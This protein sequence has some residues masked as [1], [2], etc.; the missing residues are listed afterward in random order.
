MTVYVAVNGSAFPVSVGD[1]RN[2]IDE[3]IKHT[4]PNKA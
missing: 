3:R 4:E 1:E 2:G